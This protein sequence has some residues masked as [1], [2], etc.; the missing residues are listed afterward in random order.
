MIDPAKVQYGLTK[1][2]FRVGELAKIE[3]A[4]EK[5]IGELIPIVQA[6]ARGYV[7]RFVYKSKTA[8]QFAVLTIQRNIRAWLEMRQWPWFRLWQAVKPQLKK[9][10]WETELAKFKADEKT[11]LVELEKAT[12]ERAALEKEVNSLASALDATKK[13]LDAEKNRIDSLQDDFDKAD[14]DRQKLKRKIQDVEDTIEEKVED[15][16]AVEAAIKDLRGRLDQLEGNL[17]LGEADRKKLNQLKASNEAELANIQANLDAERDAS[18]KLSKANR[19]L[20][21]QLEDATHDSQN[22]EAAIDA[23]QRI[24]KKLSDELDQLNGELDQYA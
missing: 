10:D 23:L 13:N 5:K 24:K 11:K 6:L 3:E 12:Q 8:K 19:A 20:A 9:V 7:G 22:E 15:I 17:K 14:A 16:A 21:Q 4:R 2:F 1:V 18:G